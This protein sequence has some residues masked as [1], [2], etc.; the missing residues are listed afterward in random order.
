MRRREDG[1]AGDGVAA[2]GR[3][4]RRPRP[5]VGERSCRHVGAAGERRR[6]R[7]GVRRPLPGRPEPP[8]GNGTPWGTDHSAAGPR[9]EGGPAPAG[10][11]RA[12]VPDGRPAERSGPVSGV[13]PANGGHA[14][15]PSGRTEREEGFE[16]DC[17]GVRV[18]RRKGIGAGP[19]PGARAHALG[20]DIVV[21]RGG[22][23]N[24]PEGRHLLAHGLAHVVQ[25][26]ASGRAIVSCQ[27]GRDQ[28]RLPRDIGDLRSTVQAIPADQTRA[29]RAARKQDFIAVASDPG[30]LLDF[31]RI[32]QIWLR[33]WMDEQTQA[34]RECRDLDDTL[35]KAGMQDCAK[36]RPK[37]ETG[38]RDLHPREHE[39][40]ADRSA[41]AEHYGSFLAGAHGRA[42]S[43]PSLSRPNAV[44]G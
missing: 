31:G 23:V 22:S 39:A 32:Y 38:V 6:R 3:T 42:L 25:Y 15:D 17:G 30:N 4:V 44:R 9:A 19:C 41:A 36:K 18:Q 33:H 12:R 21:A 7:G 37:F 40:A 10:W 5:A 1:R 20:R 24:V 8:A 27:E 13:V 14:L 11:R 29:N 34:R 35:R 28:E 43:D 16:H 26:G 2:R